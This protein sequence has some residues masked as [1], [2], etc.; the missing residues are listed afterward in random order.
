MDKQINNN[1]KTLFFS[2]QPN[3]ISFQV[4]EYKPVVTSLFPL[5]SRKE[6]TDIFATFY[7]NTLLQQYTNHYTSPSQI[8]DGISSF[9]L[10]LTHNRRSA[11]TVSWSPHQTKLGTQ[12][13][14]AL[15][16]VKAS[17]LSWKQICNY[18]KL[19]LIKGG[20]CPC[21]SSAFTTLRTIPI[22]LLYP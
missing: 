12:C 9:E 16:A 1:N 18:I 21:N 15:C 10:I 5:T 13:P 20:Y 11:Q 6:E 8:W 7:Y 14:T 22:T 19:A 2:I 3:N 17:V 4:A